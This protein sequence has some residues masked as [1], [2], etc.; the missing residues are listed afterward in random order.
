MIDQ[1]H[2]FISRHCMYLE[3]C[4]KVHTCICKMIGSI[5]LFQSYIYHFYYQISSIMLEFEK[6][7][8]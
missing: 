5:M 4:D 3:R 6:T 1:K 7:K 2:P 8:C